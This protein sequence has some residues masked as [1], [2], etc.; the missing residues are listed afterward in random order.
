M[1]TISY[2]AS[3]AFRNCEGVS[4]VLREMHL[5]HRGRLQL[6]E[7]TLLENSGRPLSNATRV[8]SAIIA[9]STINKHGLSLRESLPE[10]SPRSDSL[11]HTSLLSTLTQVQELRYINTWQRQKA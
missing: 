10:S 6:H 11:F 8:T 5:S 4:F 9:L 7:V 1:N 3:K 2:N